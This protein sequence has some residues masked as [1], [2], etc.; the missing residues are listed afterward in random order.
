LSRYAFESNA[1]IFITP[2]HFLL[3]KTLANTFTNVLQKIGLT[4][5][6][7]TDRKKLFD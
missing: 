3:L 1:V 5:F 2:F 4:I 6:C 7:Q